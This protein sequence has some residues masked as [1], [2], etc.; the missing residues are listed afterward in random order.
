ME[1]LKLAQC[2]TH[3]KPRWEYLFICHQS[4]CSA[5]WP[6][7]GSPY[8]S[9]S[10][11]SPCNSIAIVDKTTGVI[12]TWV[13]FLLEVDHPD[14]KQG[15]PGVLL[16]C[17]SVCSTLTT[18]IP[19]GLICKCCYFA[20]HDAG[21]PGTFL[22]GKLFMIVSSIAFIIICELMTIYERSQE[23]EKFIITQLEELPK[24]IITR[25]KW[26]L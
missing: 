18:S 21:M 16:Q 19:T 26:R 7:V 3:N 8:G 17:S 23:S 20:V 12:T 9:V 2:L 6:A 22:Y 15:V 13:R 5:W 11:E 10:L 25:I 14:V 24:Y 4:P 1:K